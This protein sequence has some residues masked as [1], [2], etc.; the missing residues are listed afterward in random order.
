VKIICPICKTATTWEE[1]PYRPFCSEKCKM[2]DLG[3]WASE[4]YRIKGR[5]P[6]EDEEKQSERDEG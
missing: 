6:S 2:K 1:N 3:K 5:S 4:D